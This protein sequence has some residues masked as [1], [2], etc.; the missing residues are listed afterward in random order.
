MEPEK[1][2]MIA[3]RQEMKCKGKGSCNFSGFKTKTIYK[4]RIMSEKVYNKHII[5]EVI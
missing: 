4:I 1:E 2:K 3:L 5:I